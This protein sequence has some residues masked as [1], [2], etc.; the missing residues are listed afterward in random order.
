[1]QLNDYQR[2]AFGTAIYRDRLDETFRVLY[3]TLGLT[4]E[5]GEIANKIKKI[6][7]DSEEDQVTREEAHI[8]AGELG[9]VL[10]YVAMLAHELGFELEY[11]ANRNLDKLENRK[12]RGVLQGSGDT[13]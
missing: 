12:L 4:G 7:R 8:I 3:T 1:M 13:R 2:Q 11:I 5:A 10:W 6:L 9:D